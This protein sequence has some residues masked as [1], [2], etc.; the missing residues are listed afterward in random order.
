[1]NTALYKKMFAEQERYRAWLLDQPPGEIL[2][3]A[4]EYTV[5][6]DILLTF[7][8][9]DVDDEQ[10]R[11]LM[12]LEDTMSE[13]F[14]TFEHQETNYMDVVSGSVY[15]LA[16]DLLFEEE[17]RKNK[18]RTLPIYYHSGEYARENGELEKYRESRAANIGCRDAIQEAIKSH[19]HENRLDPAAVSEVADKYGF[20]RVLYVLANTVRHKEWDGR[21][22]R[23]NKEWAATQ[24]I[25]EDKNGID[26]DRNCAF[27]VEAHPVLVDGY[28]DM[29]RE[30]F[31]MTRRLTAK[32]IDEE[33]KRIQSFFEKTGEP[34]S[35]NGT[36]IMVEISPK[37]MQRA[38]SDDIHNLQ[39]NLSFFDTLCFSTL[40]DR[41]GI[42]AMISK[43]Q[44][45]EWPYGVKKPSTLDMLK[46]PVKQGQ[47]AEKKVSEPER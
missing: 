18:L 33:A 17:Q 25:P 2:K 23:D 30:Q 22:S 6:E 3:H 28:I 37:F 45:R 44:I 34:N 42:F 40:N 12:A 7:E 38:S 43:D 41:K 13:I 20:H 21:F 16:N 29:A 11:V 27:C 5:R 19:Y 9:R 15:C 8:Y 10:G 26:D 47:K 35:P 24:F 4:Y 39:G 1:M 46:Q 36:H 14:K 32:E 31:L